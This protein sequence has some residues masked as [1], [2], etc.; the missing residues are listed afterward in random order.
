VTKHS[1]VSIVCR[2][3]LAA[4]FMRKII[5]NAG[6]P[7]HLAMVNSAK[8]WFCSLAGQ[9]CTVLPSSHC[10]KEKELCNLKIEQT[11]EYHCNKAR[12]IYRVIYV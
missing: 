10:A 4:Q 11:I 5:A 1:Y 7:P 2:E 8:E 9:F 3:K 6:R 12:N